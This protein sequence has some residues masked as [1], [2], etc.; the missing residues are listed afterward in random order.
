VRQAE[1]LKPM[2]RR[3]FED[4]GIERGMRV[5]DLGSGPGDVCL[6]LAEMVGSTGNVI[7]L[8]QDADVVHFAQERATA[9]GLRN[10][11]F[12]HSEFSLYVPEAPL[13]AVVGRSVLLYQKDPVAALATVVKHL[14]P[15]GIVAFM[16]PWLA[17][18]QGPD[19]PVLRVLTCIVETLRRSGTH[20]DLGP[21]LH[22]VFASAGLPQPKMRFEAVMDARDKSP[23]YQLVADSFVSLLPKAVEYG[24]A[25]PD[26][27]DVESIPAQ[28]RATMN[29]VGYAAMS[30]PTVSAWCRTAQ[31]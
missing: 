22:K 2:T 20:I 27:V 19:N 28:L 29:A 7:G 21:R 31:A 10:I 26:E 25:S 30:L 3:V 1:F 9:A 11:T 17:L 6:L 23:L 18:P 13:D 4:A 24:I 16:E 8:E 15:G 14:R 5:L 12:V